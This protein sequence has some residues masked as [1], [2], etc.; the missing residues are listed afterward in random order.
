MGGEAM[1]LFLTAEPAAVVRTALAAALDLV[2]FGVVLLNPAMQPRFLNRHFVTMWALPDDL[3]APGT[4]FRQLL[5]HV[6][7]SCAY[8]VSPADV[9]A[10]IDQR[11]GA[12]RD[13]TVAPTVIDLTDGRR[14]LFR[15]VIAADGSRI[16]T[17]ID[18]TRQKQEQDIQ[19]HARDAAERNG[20]ELRFSNESLESQAAYLASLAEAADAA[21]QRAD[22]AKRRLEHEMTEQQALEAQLRRMATTDA[23]TGAMNP[24]QLLTLGQ[25]ELERVRTTGQEL[26]V[27]MLDIDHFE[28]INDRYGH[29]CGDEV[30]RNVVGQ[31]SSCVRRIDL[32]GRLGGKEFAVILPAI[33]AT[34][35]LRAAERLRSHVAD[36]AI[37]FGDATI[38]LTVSIGVAMARDTDRSIE[39]ALAR[40]DAALSTARGAGRNRVVSCDEVEPVA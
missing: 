29:P 23:L 24:A 31:L 5:D 36:T 2:D 13:G 11:E 12:V 4:T 10:Y 9:A 28:S 6:G 18:I 25:R 34:T 27:V 33:P 38:R 37:V 19:Q 22:Q 1:P 17:Y 7:N 15:C 32:V 8:H 21:A 39:Q 35:A 16:L 14:I 3:L 40:A 30:L 26:A 20:V